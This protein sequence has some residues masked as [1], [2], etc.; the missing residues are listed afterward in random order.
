MALYHKYNDLIRGGDYYRIASYREN[1]SH[2]CWAVAAKDRSE[3][4]VTWVQ[5]LARANVHSRRV[6]LRGFDPKARYRLEDTEQI[7]AGEMLLRGGFLMENLSGDYKS[8]ICRFE[9][10]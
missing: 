6:R 2:D 5:V 9:R 7:Y 1:H 8:R 3:V 10:V 4:L